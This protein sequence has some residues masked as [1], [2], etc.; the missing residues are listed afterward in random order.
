VPVPQVLRQGLGAG[1]HPSAY[2]AQNCKNTELI[3]CTFRTT[4]N[5]FPRL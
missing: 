3:F 4:G 1:E 2:V 5:I